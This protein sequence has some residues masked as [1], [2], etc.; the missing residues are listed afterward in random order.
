[1]KP[2]VDENGRVVHPHGWDDIDQQR[3]IARAVVNRI[4]AARSLPE[5]WSGTGGTLPG[6]LAELDDEQLR[7]WSVDD[8]GTMREKLA[9]VDQRAGTGLFYTPVPVA[10]FMSRFSLDVALKQVVEPG[11]PGSVLRALALDPACGAGVLLVEAARHI[12]ARYAAELLGGEPAEAMIRLVL[13]EVMAECVFGLDIDPVAIDLAK[14]A[15]WL[16]T[17]GTR[18]ITFLDR[19]VIVGNPLA[20]PDAMPPKLEERWPTPREA[21]EAFAQHL[22]LSTDG[23]GGAAACSA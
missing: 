13:P 12:A 11:D 14:S 8:L 4:A 3:A 20:S 9:S 5:P 16:E 15:L 17:L 18:P 19:N 10:T 22:G 6:W 23:E 1:M 2:L 7:R 21:R